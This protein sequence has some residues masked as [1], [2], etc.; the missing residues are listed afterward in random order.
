MD[1]FIIIGVVAIAATIY[2][3]NE[4]MKKRDRDELKKKV[5]EVANKVRSK[6]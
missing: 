3:Y 6:L 4:R 1:V 5:E 2:W